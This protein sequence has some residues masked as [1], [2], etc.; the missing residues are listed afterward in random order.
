MPNQP[1]RNNRPIDERYKG[2]GGGQG[3]PR[4]PSGVR[5][6]WLPPKGN[7]AAVNGDATPPTPPAPQQQGETEQRKMS[8]PDAAN[9]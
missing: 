3:P 5:L 1:A 2:R 6:T 7:M 8:E 9:Q 4:T